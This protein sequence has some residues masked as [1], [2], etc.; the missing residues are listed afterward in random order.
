MEKQDYSQV[1]YDTYYSA[2]KPLKIT[3]KNGKVLEGRLIGV[4]HGEPDSSDPF[5]IRW[6]F[7]GLGEHELESIGDG[8]PGAYLNQEDIKTVEF[9]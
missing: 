1:I 3:L 6:H 2:N 9:K 8:E 4:F 5:V 7:I